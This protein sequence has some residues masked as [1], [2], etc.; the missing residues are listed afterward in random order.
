[1]LLAAAADRARRLLVL[2]YPDSPPDGSSAWTTS[3][4]G[5]GRR[6]FRSHVHEPSH[7][8][9][10]LQDHGLHNGSWHIALAEGNGA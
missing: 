5:V 2:T 7:M 9:A 10:V 8:L 3:P 4:S 6:Q 1:M